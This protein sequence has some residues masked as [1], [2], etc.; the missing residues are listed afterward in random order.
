MNIRSEHPVDRIAAEERT[1]S[2]PHELNYEVLE[3]KN[4]RGWRW[5]CL[6]IL[7]IL[8]FVWPLVLFGLG[9]LVGTLG[10]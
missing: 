2:G 3:L 6:V 10:R 8:V 1:Q 4:K 5:V 7:A 9:L